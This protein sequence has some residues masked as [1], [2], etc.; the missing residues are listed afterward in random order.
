M[1]SKLIVIC[2][3]I[4]KI[5][6]SLR[7]VVLLIISF[8]AYYFYK[9]YIATIS[10]I[11]V[12]S[13]FLYT[14]II[15]CIIFFV[16]F[17]W[18]YL[19]NRKNNIADNLNNICKEC[20]QGR[21]SRELS[22]ETY[23]LLTKDDL[24]NN[25]EKN[26]NKDD[27]VII[28]TS[29]AETESDMEDIVKENKDKGV[30]YH[31]L[32]YNGFDNIKSKYYRNIIDLIKLNYGKGIDFEL[33]KNTGFD[34]FTVKRKNEKFAEAFFAVNYSVGPCLDIDRSIYNCNDSCDY[35]NTFLFYKKIE[36]Q[37][38]DTVFNILKKIVKTYE[39][40]IKRNGENG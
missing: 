34:I 13:L 36:E 19:I 17:F 38:A 30:I 14:V 24:V 1:K 9:S 33:S 18:D 10:N 40:E 26:L 28:Y 37:I 25:I 20:V 5:K 3:E 35:S 11:S 15:I 23:G 2:K 31:L 29:L 12:L 16:N 22:L 39:A 4:A 27:E 7:F 8:I 21:I 6:T 32:F